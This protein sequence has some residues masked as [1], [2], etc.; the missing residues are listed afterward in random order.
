MP[1]KLNKGSHTSE[2]LQIFKV[3]RPWLF[4]T[5]TECHTDSHYKRPFTLLLLEIKAQP[6]INIKINWALLVSQWSQIFLHA[7]CGCFFITKVTAQA[8]PLFAQMNCRY[9]WISVPP[10][11]PLFIKTVMIPSPSLSSFRLNISFLWCLL[12]NLWNIEDQLPWVSR[13]KRE[14]VT[15]ERRQEHY[16]FNV[17]V[18]GV[19]QDAESRLQVQNRVLQLP[20]LV[21]N[22]RLTLLQQWRLVL[23]LWHRL[24][25]QCPAPPQQGK[26]ISPDSNQSGIHLFL[27]ASQL[28][29]VCVT[30][31]NKKR[32]FWHLISI[33]SFLQ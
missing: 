20:V 17:G 33:S 7:F 31:N 12:R 3:T 25:Q 28:S 30:A 21:C 23:Q 18:A 26:A 32:A 8:P 13:R 4:E 10:F 5:E 15:G 19:L 14:N 11:I 29:A 9:T 27:K 1:F 24:V 22:L 6:N 16:P 2:V